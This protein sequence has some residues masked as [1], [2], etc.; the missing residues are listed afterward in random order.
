MLAH[1][2]AIA[3][4]LGSFI[5]YI[6]A[7]FFPE[8]H[9]PRDLVWSGVG[10]FYALVLWVCA[11]QLTGAVLL[12]QTASVA[13]LGW[14]GWQTL[15][16]RRLKTPVLDQTEVSD[17]AVAQVKQRFN[18]GGLFRRKS[19][20]QAPP[21]TEP[22]ATES[23]VTS[24]EQP[25]SPG[26][27]EPKSPSSESEPEVMAPSTPE[28]STLE[29]DGLEGSEAFEESAP[30]TDGDQPDPGDESTSDP[31]CEPANSSEKT[32]PEPEVFPLPV[33][34][35]ASEPEAPPLPTITEVSTEDLEGIPDEDISNIPEPDVVKDLE[36]L[37]D[38]ADT[39]IEGDNVIKAEVVKD[40]DPDAWG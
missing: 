37:A 4:A 24:A 39:D 12:G 32:G 21:V 8:I 2:L 5:F 18:W 10:L 30:K 25:E 9:R 36:A 13:L 16:L 27:P 31:D 35:A 20:E 11:G 28:A 15:T 33:P 17:Q 34:E 3:V 38:I 29:P 26:E 1:I 7:F 23:A 19:E 14:L 6:A 40:T 22:A